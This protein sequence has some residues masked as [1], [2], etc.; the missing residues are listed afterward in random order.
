MRHRTFVDGVREQFTL[1]VDLHNACQVLVANF[2][3]EA[4]A[5]ATV[6]ALVPSLALS[7]ILAIVC[8]DSACA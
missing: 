2:P 4:G 6:G 3:V 8:P 7:A 1:E 5:G